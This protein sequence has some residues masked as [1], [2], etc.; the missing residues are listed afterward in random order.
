MKTSGR[1]QQDVGGRAAGS[2]VPEPLRSMTLV[3]MIA[4]AAVFIYLLRNVLLPF[5]VAGIVAY[6][7][8]PLVT[9]LSKKTSLPRWLFALAVL[10][11]LLGVAVIVGLL[12]APSLFHELLEIGGNMHG[13]V[14][15]L[16]KKVIGEG[17]VKLFGKPVDAQSIANYAVKGVQ[18]WF[19]ASGVF[20]LGSISVAGL[21]GFVLTWV[22][23]GYLLIDGPRVGQGILWIV[24]PSRRLGAVRIW[25]GLDPILRRYFVGIAIVVLYGSAAAYIG[26]NLFLGLR[27]ALVLALL[28]GLLEIIPLVGPAASGI[29]A[30][31]AAVQEAKSGWDIIA[32]IIY[33]VALRVSIDQLVGPMVLGKAASVH[34]VVVI[35]CFL[36]GAALFGIIGMVLA[37][38]VAVTTK[39]ILGL[40]YEQH[41]TRA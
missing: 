3:E 8:T 9:W 41:P 39:I 28:T 22:L 36:A 21:F 13:A 29:I 10:M 12:A 18:D 20:E 4:A 34:P 16:A 37:V 33:A 24:P 25:S 5:V 15:N 19:G 2:D 32:Y 1:D 14:E 23:L 6:V 27:H 30:G 17:S 7:F 35:F 26:L 31:L 38:P 11:T 40:V